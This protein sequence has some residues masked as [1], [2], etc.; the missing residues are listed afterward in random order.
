[1]LQMVEM[2]RKHELF[3]SSNTANTWQLKT[4]SISFGRRPRLMGIVNVTPDSFSDGGRFSDARAAVDQALALVR[5]GAEILDIGGE[6]TRPYAEPVDP[7]EE[8]RR[9]RDVIAEVCQLTGR[10]RFD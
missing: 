4:R 8:L 5:D 3:E 1:M 2:L 6:S 7:V 10:A 9:T